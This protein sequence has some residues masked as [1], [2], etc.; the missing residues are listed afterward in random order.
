MIKLFKS[1]SLLEWLL[2]VTS[3]LGFGMIA[4][5]LAFLALHP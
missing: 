2:L 1:L 3:S 4:Y 5:I